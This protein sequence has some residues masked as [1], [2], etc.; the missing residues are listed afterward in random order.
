MNLLV[1]I[2]SEDQNS[3][4]THLFC[5]PVD[6]KSAQNLRARLSTELQHYWLL[7]Q[8]KVNCLCLPK[9]NLSIIIDIHAGNIL[10]NSEMTHIDP[11]TG[12]KT[13]P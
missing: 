13:L 6:V 11:T 4:D 7:S 5:F 8:I 9:S 2:K 10:Q 12:L 1:W 3:F